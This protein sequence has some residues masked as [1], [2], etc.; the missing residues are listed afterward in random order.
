MKS[1]RFSSDF[2][3]QVPGHFSVHQMFLLRNTKLG[4]VFAESAQ[5]LGISEPC[6]AVHGGCISQGTEL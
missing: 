5:N 6:K 1:I 4:E 2:Q 3:Q